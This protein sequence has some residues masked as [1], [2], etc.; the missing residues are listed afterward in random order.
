MKND[1]INIDK[2]ESFKVS[3]HYDEPE[4]KNYDALKEVVS[5]VANRY[6]NYIIT[7]E[8]E[9]MEVNKRGGL[10]TKLRKVSKTINEYKVDVHRK[11]KE[12]YKDFDTKMNEL[13]G[14]VNDSIDS[15]KKQVDDYKQRQEMKMINDTN[16]LFDE[17][18]ESNQFKGKLPKW[19]SYQLFAKFNPKAFK[20]NDKQKKKT[21]IDFLAKVHQDSNE[22]IKKYK[23]YDSKVFLEKTLK[24]YLDDMDINKA[25]RIGI[26]QHNYMINAL[27]EMQKKA[28]E[29]PKEEIIH[30][31]EDQKKQVW[32]TFSTPDKVIAQKLKKILDDH[33]IEYEL[34][35]E[36]K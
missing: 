11:A 21:I 16:D 22:I 10:L 17:L 29:K 27:S 36:I 30:E 1:L 3:Y 9:A 19:C 33:H 15:V 2:I 6:Q 20:L 13:S 24:S 5:E 12:S 7:S 4:L 28:E 8:E 34:K 26:E 35:K 31:K 14:L 18:K 25:I 23:E 32:Y